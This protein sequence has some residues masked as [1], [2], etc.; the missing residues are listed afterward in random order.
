MF[1]GNKTSFHFSGCPLW[2]C[3]PVFLLR[4][5][6]KN[7]NSPFTRPVQAPP[8]RVS[9]DNWGKRRHLQRVTTLLLPHPTHTDS[10]TDSS[11]HSF[12]HSS[13]INPLHHQMCIHT[14]N[15]PHRH[16]AKHNTQAHTL[17]ALCKL[18]HKPTATCRYFIKRHTHTQNLGNITLVLDCTI[19]MPRIGET[20]TNQA[21]D[22][23]ITKVPAGHKTWPYAW[24]SAL[25]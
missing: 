8:T 3:C 20:D 24:S 11:S 9:S 15:L 14:C 4:P 17:L 10:N 16:T 12:S 13:H 25:H 7:S 5:T 6:I 2:L 1:W 18:P 21:T 19:P 22:P 23:T